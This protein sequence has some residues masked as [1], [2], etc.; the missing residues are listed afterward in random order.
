LFWR[1]FAAFWLANVA[2]IIALAWI[3]TRNFELE[4]I[5]GLEITRLQA[6]MDDQLARLARDAR[7]GGSEKLDHS[8]RVAA[9]MGPIA[10][11]AIDANDN[12]RLAQSLSPEVLD[13]VRSLRN[14]TPLASDRMRATRTTL[15]DDGRELLLVAAAEGP[16]W[17]RLLYKRPFGFWAHIGLALIASALAS[18]LLAWYVAAPLARIRTSTRRFAEG[19]LDARVGRLRFGRSAEM[20]ALAAEFDHMAERIKTLV[21]NNRRLVRDVSH[22]LRSPL[23][24]LRVALELARGQQGA[25]VEQSMDR[26]ER[27]SDRLEAMLAQ[28]IELSRLETRPER[29]VEAIALDE[30]IEDVIANADYES[31]PL[32][33]KVVLESSAPLTTK[34]SRDAL[35]S[36]IENVVRNA[37]AYTAGASSIEVNLDLDPHAQDMA[38]IRIRDHGAGVA[39]SDLERIFEP[40]YRT[41][42]ARARSSGGTGLGLA[43]AKRAIDNQ[44]GRINARNAEGGGLEVVITL[45]RTVSG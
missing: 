41:D 20:T 30:L 27:E 12:D 10:F 24:R 31:A 38:R 33:R 22:E 37:I 11:Y 26:I 18:A 29:F 7:R 14:Q 15:R 1:I 9:S 17:G 45:P 28:A 32:G 43:I 34:G 42:A 36:A 2:I 19:D 39:D 23:A 3:T 13:A 5:P 25:A 6:A 16:L 4:R 40:F 21:E 8:L 44:G 35:Y